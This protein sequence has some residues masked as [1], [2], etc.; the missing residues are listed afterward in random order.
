MIN[1]IPRFYE[2]TEGSVLVDGKNVKSYPVAELRNKIA[3]VP[4]KAVLFSGS[5]R[6]NLRWGKADATDDDIMK[7]VKYSQ[8]SDFIS[9]AEDLDKYIFQGGRNL[10]GGQKQRL[11]IARALVK[12]PEILI[13]DDSASALDYTTDLRLRTAIKNLSH[14][15][16][17]FIVSQRAASVMHADIILVL[18][19]GELVGA[20][21]HDQLIKTCGEYIQICHSQMSG[22]EAENER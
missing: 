11:T 5:V 15:M 12:E 13:L 1:L 17:V 20:G 18:D 21:T 8:S 14:S 3:V 6:D 19:N 7:A 2:A 4:Q 22:S 9:S 10:S 16:T